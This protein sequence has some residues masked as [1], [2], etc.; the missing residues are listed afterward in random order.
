[1]KPLRY[2]IVAP[3]V[4][5]GSLA[6][7]TTTS[8]AFAY[9]GHAGGHAGGGHATAGHYSGH[10]VAQRRGVVAHRPPAMRHEN[11]GVRPSARHVWRGG[12]WA[13]GGNRY[14]WAGGG[15]AIPPRVGLVW[16]P[17][18]W[19]ATDGGWVWVGGHWG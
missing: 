14:Y 19:V 17:G 15:W 8:S 5:L 11:Y 16:M 4:A 13:W 2:L 10:T 1:M 6:A 12:H 7:A 9:G 18:Q 3:L